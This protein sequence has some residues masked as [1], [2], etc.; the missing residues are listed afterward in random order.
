MTDDDEEKR[1]WKEFG[2]SKEDISDTAV[3]AAS[4]PLHPV[5]A[6]GLGAAVLVNVGFLLSIPPVLRGR[7]MCVCV[8]SS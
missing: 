3:V 6:V 1:I 4:K 2:L 7:G 8:A 5:L